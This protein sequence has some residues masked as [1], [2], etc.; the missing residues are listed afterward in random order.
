MSSK[1]FFRMCACVVCGVYIRLLVL[2]HALT[3]TFLHYPNALTLRVTLD[4]EDEFVILA[5]DGIWDCLTNEEAVQYVRDR[6]DT[7]TPI[8]VGTEM[9]DEIISVDPR[10]T[11]GI[12]GDNMTVMV[13]DLLPGRRSYNK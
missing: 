9:L 13:V 3:H 6:I 5:C 11:S 4:P 2:K 12:G 7:K 1:C 10:E 8:E